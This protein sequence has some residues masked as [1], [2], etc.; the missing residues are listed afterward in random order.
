MSVYV[1]EVGT[2]ISVAR[3]GRENDGSTMVPHLLIAQLAAASRV[4]VMRDKVDKLLPRPMSSAILW[5]SLWL[6]IPSIG[7][8]TYLSY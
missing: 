3:E 6:P 2:I 8:D 1:L 7:V 5:G 4:L